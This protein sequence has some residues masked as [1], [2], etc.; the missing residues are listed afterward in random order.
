MKLA[1]AGKGGVGKTTLSS[2]LCYAF[3]EDGKDVIAV[4]ANPDSN[5]G[6]ALGFSK[7]ELSSLKPIAELDEI[8]RERTG[9]TGGVFRLNPKV[10]DI[11][12]RFSLRKG[13]LRFILMGKVKRGGEGCFCPES[14]F[15]RSLLSHLVLRSREVVVMD[16]DAGVENLTRG[17]A[18]GVDALIVVVEPGR[19]S[20]ETA[21]AVKELSHDLGINKVYAVGNKIRGD[22]ASFLKESIPLQFLGFIKFDERL[23]KADMEGKP[24]HTASPEAFREAKSIKSKLEGR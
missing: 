2:L 16:M 10:D 22:E 14:A 11:P 15:L 7:D 8:I 3:L 12:E 21:L 24:P 5:L 9:I 6:E 1:I 20:I 23:I 4:D 19:R 17:T 18:R 13:R